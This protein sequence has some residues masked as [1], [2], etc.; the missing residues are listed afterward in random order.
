M[1]LISVQRV[2]EKSQ[3][4]ERHD[5]SRDTANDSTLLNVQFIE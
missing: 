2:I 4:I 1:V 3:L 5:S